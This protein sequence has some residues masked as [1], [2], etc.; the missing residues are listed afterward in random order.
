M[1]GCKARDQLELFVTGSLD[2]L[3]PEDQARDA[4]VSADGS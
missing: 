4:V 2:Q 1:L 3:V